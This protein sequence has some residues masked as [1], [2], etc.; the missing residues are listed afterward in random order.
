MSIYFL[1]TAPIVIVFEQ[2]IV[3]ALHCLAKLLACNKER[4]RKQQDENKSFNQN[5]RDHLF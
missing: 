2:W 1:W 3:G 4:K 5:V